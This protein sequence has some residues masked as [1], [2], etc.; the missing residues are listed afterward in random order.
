[1]RSLLVVTLAL[2][3]GVGSVVPARAETGVHGSLQPAK[4]EAQRRF[5][6]GIELYKEANLGAALAEFK[7]AYEL[8]PNY[9]ILYNLGQVSY[10]RRD[11]AAALRYFRQYLG[12]G[13]DAIAVDRQNEVAAEISDLEHRV[14][15]FEIE[16]VDEGTEIF[17][18][19]MLVGTTPLHTLIPVNVGRRKVDVI[20]RGG[21]HRTRMVD[22]AG[23]EITRVSFG[24]LATA[25]AVDPAPRQ[26]ALELASP[27][28]ETTTS[29][30]DATVVAPIAAPAPAV[31]KSSF[32][33]KSWTLTGL[34]AG[35]AATTGI[36][37]WQ[38]QQD[39]DGQRMKFPADYDEID[40]E[41]RKTRGFA[42]ATDGLLIGTAVMTAVSLYL[43]LR[44]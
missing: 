20:A 11:Y 43:T 16:T 33:W 40:Y 9:K 26:I 13:D 34:L 3:V 12:D 19:D 24:R 44:D 35:A 15:R 22:V 6:R 2:A 10:Q 28:P 14:G 37:A 31:R 5:Y 32:P 18:D 17:V 29:T 27:P 4:G 36:I 38:T 42:L 41:M 8:S 1:M 30:A 21:E 25:T 23:G 39:L 7:R